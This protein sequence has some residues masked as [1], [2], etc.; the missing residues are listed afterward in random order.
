MSNYLSVAYDHLSRL[1]HLQRSLLKFGWHLGQLT[2]SLARQGF[3]KPEESKEAENGD[4]AQLEGTG[5]GEG[6]GSNNVSN[7]ITDEGQ[8][9]GLQDQDSTEKPSSEQDD[10]EAVD[11]DQDFGGETED[12]ADAPDAGDREDDDKDDEQQTE[13]DIADELGNVNPTDPNSIDEKFWN[14]ESGEGETPKGPE[15]ELDNSAGKP[16]DGEVGERNDEKP[17]ESGGLP[18]QADKGHQAEEASHKGDELDIEQDD[19]ESLSGASENAETQRQELPDVIEE[20]VLDLPEDLNCDPRL[21]ENDATG[22]DDEL[23][24]TDGEC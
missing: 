17:D 11:M 2:L 21:D 4:S 22:S 3:C 7:Q 20:E 10:G 15:E 1:L 9:E 8:I 24:P 14:D 5:M 18:D 23:E 6:A 13:D 12:V 16:E 19:A